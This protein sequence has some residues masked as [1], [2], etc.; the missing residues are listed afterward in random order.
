MLSASAFPD[1]FLTALSVSVP[2]FGWVVL[3]MVLRRVGVLSPTFI[4]AVSRLAFNVGLP[5]M[6]FVSAAGIDFSGLG[7]ATYLLAGV[8]ATVT[9]LAASWVYGRWRGFS[10]PVLG[11]FVQA[12]FRS[13]LAII[14]FA[15]CHA[16]YG[17]QGLML[18]AL[19]V[20]LMTA[21]YNVLAV[22]VLQVTHGGSRSVLGI[23]RGIIVNPLLIGIFAGVC[24]ALSGL[25]LPA[26]AADVGW[27]LSQF[28]LPLM[29]ACIGGAM[30]IG[31]IRTAGAVT[32]EATAWRLCVA[33]LLGM[34]VAIAMGIEGAQLGVL[35]LLLSSPVA[36]ASFVMVVAARGDGTLAA[37]IIVLTTL[38]SIVTVTLGFAAL[39][40]AGLAAVPV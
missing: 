24:V 15:L 19:P 30:R 14:G 18:A 17:E 7:G 34:L 27:G 21:L 22:W 20:A 37:N 8:I 2:T 38:L 40:L 10:H 11:V 3:G 32:W 35:F 25:P 39:V 23:L 5:L 26:V 31:V 1:L 16:A 33:P 9:T 36:A 12:S 28:F 29:L 4:D 6:L 13:N